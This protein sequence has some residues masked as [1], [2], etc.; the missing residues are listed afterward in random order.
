MANALLT[1]PDWSDGGAFTSSVASGNFPV[2]NLG[3]LSLDRYE[4]TAP[5]S[6]TIDIDHSTG[7]TADM[8][9]FA[10]LYT[11]ASASATWRITVADTFGD[12]TGE[13]GTYAQ[14][15][16]PT[17]MRRAITDYT[18][19]AAANRIHAYYV[20]SAVVTHRWVRFTI[21][22]TVNSTFRAR[23]AMVGSHDPFA[24][25]NIGY[26]SDY[27]AFS[28]RSRRGE[29][30][31]GRLTM[32]RGFIAQ[33]ESFQGFFVT[34]ADM[35][36]LMK[37]YEQRGGSQDWLFV[38]DR[39]TALTDRMEESVVSGYLPTKFKVQHTSFGL[40]NFQSEIVER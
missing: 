23:R 18:D 5:T 7:A 16:A 9:T 14:L 17:L 12:L 35:K 24:N 32:S 25:L 40:F 2:A 30:S 13:T 15:L 29:S 21:A 39:N 31:R 28:D 3:K 34:E 1:I 33:E 20:H 4:N 8:L 26:G 36:T 38:R 19:P 27:G 37:M 22:E 10:L 11:N 6:F